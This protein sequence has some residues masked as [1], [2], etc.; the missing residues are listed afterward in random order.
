[1]HTFFDGVGDQVCL[2]RTGLES[3]KPHNHTL[4]VSMVS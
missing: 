4:A 1:M 2:E 3:Y